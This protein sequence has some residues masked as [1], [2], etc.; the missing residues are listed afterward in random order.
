M[1]TK[2]ALL[3]FRQNQDIKEVLFCKHAGKPFYVLPGGKKEQAETIEQALQREL[4]EELGVD[5]DNV[6]QVGVAKGK[7]PDGQ[8]MEMHLYTGELRGEPQAQAEIEYIEW[9]SEAAIQD[10]KDMMTPMTLQH[11]IPLLKEK[12][13]F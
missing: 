1:I 11:I 13:L 12:G 5:A 10:K 2:A 7:T 9:M 6:L 4:Q 8:D 3:L